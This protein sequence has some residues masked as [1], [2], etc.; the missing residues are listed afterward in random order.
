MA[1]FIFYTEDIL[2]KGFVMQ[3][4][5][6]SDD[7]QVRTVTAPSSAALFSALG[8]TE[9]TGRRKT[10]SEATCE[11]PYVIKTG[12]LQYCY[13]VDQQDEKAYGQACQIK[14]IKKIHSAA[15]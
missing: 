8:L 2:M 15:E 5:E 7:A 1:R 11:K 12:N 14:A 4:A 10:I 13:I 6:G 3:F 9:T